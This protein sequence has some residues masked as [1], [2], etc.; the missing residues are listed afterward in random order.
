[1]HSAGHNVYNNTILNTK[2][3]SITA[4]GAADVNIY[5]NTMSK[6]FVGVL[7]ASGFENINIQNNTYSLTSTMFP[8]TFPYYILIADSSTNSKTVANGTFTDSRLSIAN[9][10]LDFIL[11]KFK[12][13]QR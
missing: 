5:N 10:S 1:M 3:S 6:S 12:C 13:N 8:P 4:Y 7:L 11:C 9:I 2:L